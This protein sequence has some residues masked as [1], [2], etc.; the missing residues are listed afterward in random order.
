MGTTYNYMDKGVIQSFNSVTAVK[1][2]IIIFL[3]VISVL[4]IMRLIGLRSLFQDRGITAELENINAIKKRDKQILRANHLLKRITKLV[5][6]SGLNIGTKKYEYVEYNLRR[7]G[8]KIPGGFRVLTPDEFNACCKIGSLITTA[9]GIV[10][11]ATASILFGFVIIVGCAVLW[12]IVPM[13]IIRGI[14]ADKDAEIK[15]NFFDLYLMLHYTLI[16]GAKTPIAKLFKSYGKQT[17]SEE[18]I[19]FTANC[20]DFLDTYGEFNATRLIAKEYREIAEVGRLM[21]LIRQQQDGGDITQELL[22]FKSQLVKEREYEVEQRM[23]K[24]VN[25]AN[26]SF[27][28]LM[29]ILI[30]AIISAMSIYLPDIASVTSFF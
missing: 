16:A 9:I 26:D 25:R 3:V 11:L 12:N 27:K 21:R 17:N 13:M 28:V 4:I 20:V 29:I 1:V 8:V 7:A 23:D 15:R 19:E 24:L 30:Q 5:N 2:L 22:G 10:V 6:R 18:M 14:V